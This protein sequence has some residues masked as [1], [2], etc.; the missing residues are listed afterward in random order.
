MGEPVLDLDSRRLDRSIARAVDQEP[1]HRMYGSRDYI[2][3]LV[4]R[5]R[6]QA[7]AAADGAIEG[8]VIYDVEPVWF[9]DLIEVRTGGDRSVSSL[10]AQAD[11]PSWAS[12][13]PLR[14][15]T[16]DEVIAGWDETLQNARDAP[17]VVVV[18]LNSLVEQALTFDFGYIA[19]KRDVGSLRHLTHSRYVDEIRAA[20]RLRTAQA[21]GRLQPS[22]IATR[23]QAVNANNTTATFRVT[24]QGV[25]V[26]PSWEEYRQAIR[27]TDVQIE[28]EVVD[29]DEYV[30]S[31]WEPDAE[32]VGWDGNLVWV[33]VNGLD[34]QGENPLTPGYERGGCNCASC[35]LDRAL[36]DA[37]VEDTPEDDE[38][39]EEDEG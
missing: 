34:T 15:M 25:P 32:V 12:F 26:S 2:V 39:Y 37:D 38:D 16:D 3:E 23:R 7:R 18:E 21:R 20:D 8:S 35:R 6:T 14:Q 24:A 4:R 5:I 1:V 27:H 22:Y 36:A 33:D 17:H 31:D 10:L 9:D 11:Q 19:V 13:W 29:G 30:A 28:A